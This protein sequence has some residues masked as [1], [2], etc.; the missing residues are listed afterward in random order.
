MDRE[1]VDRLAFGNEVV[2]APTCP[3]NF[4]WSQHL[5][6]CAPRS[7]Y[8]P[9]CVAEQS[10]STDLEKCIDRCKFNYV[11]INMKNGNGGKCVVKPTWTRATLSNC[12]AQGKGYSWL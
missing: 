1:N 2:I 11:W 8:A 7:E 10:W 9:T 6:K 4:E 12:A 5:G 3:I